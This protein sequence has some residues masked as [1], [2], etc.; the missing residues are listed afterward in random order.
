MGKNKYFTAGGKKFTRE[1]FTKGVYRRRG[2]YIEIPGVAILAYWKYFKWVRAGFSTC[3]N[4]KA[5]QR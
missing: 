3:F 1:A 2:K 4:K 5:Y